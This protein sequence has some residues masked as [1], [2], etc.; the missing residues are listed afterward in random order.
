MRRV[1]DST[2]LLRKNYR[3]LVFFVAFN[4]HVVQSELFVLVE[5]AMVADDSQVGIG[6]SVVRQ[7]LHVAVPAR[8]I[9]D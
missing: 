8:I 3:R 1:T 6:S 5:R 9:K 2:P 4:F 7:R